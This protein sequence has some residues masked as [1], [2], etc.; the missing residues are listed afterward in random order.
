MLFDILDI[1][2]ALP[3][4]VEEQQKWKVVIRFSVEFRRIDQ[5]IE[6]RLTLA[7]KACSHSRLALGWGHPFLRR[8]FI[9]NKL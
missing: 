5:V 6:G 7:D 1:I 2:A 9:I 4:S 3:A 8:S